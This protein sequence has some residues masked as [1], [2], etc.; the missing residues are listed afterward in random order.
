M[1]A[2]ASSPRSSPAV[3]IAY[4]ER[5]LPPETAAAVERDLR[6]GELDG[7]AELLLL[8][9]VT[10]GSGPHWVCSSRDGSPSR[11]RRCPWLH[12]WSRAAS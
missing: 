7:A 11:C 5:R 2:T 1:V 6:G 4:F 9:L 8:V 12:S 3:T 10:A